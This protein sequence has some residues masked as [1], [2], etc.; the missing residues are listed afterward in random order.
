MDLASSTS[1]SLELPTALCGPACVCEGG[2]GG[3]GG[4]CRALME[5]CLLSSFP[6]LK[7]SQ[8]K[9]IFFHEKL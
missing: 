5:G 8:S 3:G 2:G 9:K 1:L 7:Y 4:G 6:Y